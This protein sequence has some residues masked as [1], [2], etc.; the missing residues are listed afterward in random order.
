[1][2]HVFAPVLPGAV[3]CLPSGNAA[4]THTHTPG[5]RR[6]NNNSSNDNNSNNNTSNNSNNTK[7][8]WVW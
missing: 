5:G 3:A 4:H 7:A 6:T 1:M 2:R 8:V